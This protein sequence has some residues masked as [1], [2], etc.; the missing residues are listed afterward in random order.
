M[1]IKEGLDLVA[2]GRKN[3][4]VVLTFHEATLKYIV[5]IKFEMVFDLAHVI[6]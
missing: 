2:Y 4:K 6:F 3:V 1:C 5:N